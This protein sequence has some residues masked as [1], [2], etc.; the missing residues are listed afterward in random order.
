MEAFLL[1]LIGLAA[2]HGVATARSAKAPELPAIQA[3]ERPCLAS[4]DSVWIADLE[5]RGAQRW[6]LQSDGTFCAPRGEKLGDGETPEPSM[7]PE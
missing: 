3:V 4:P 7:I 6:L 5:K 2:G 1:F